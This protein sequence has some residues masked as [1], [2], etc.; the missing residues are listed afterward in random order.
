VLNGALTMS[1]IAEIFWGLGLHPNLKKSENSVREAFQWQI[2]RTENPMISFCT[3]PYHAP[4]WLTGT[5][6]SAV[7]AYTPNSYE[8]LVTFV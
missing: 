4:I 1:Q 8:T 2:L 7:W 5:E 3:N 6:F